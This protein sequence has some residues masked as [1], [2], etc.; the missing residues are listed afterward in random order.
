[1]LQTAGAGVATLALS[2]LSLLAQKEEAKGFT[3][4]K[5]P[6]AYD[7][8]E[9]YIDAET[10]KIHHDKHHAAYV[11]NL[12]AALKGHPKFLSMSIDELM[13]NVGEVPAKIRQAVIDNGGGHLNHS[14]FWEI[15]GPKKGGEPKGALAKAIDKAFGSFEKFKKEL[16]TAAATQFGSGWGWLA[17]ARGKLVVLKAA[18]QD[19]TYLAGY[20]PLLGVDVWEHAYYLKYKNERPKY[21]AA[22]WNVVNW[23]AVA[24]RYGAKG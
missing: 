6:Y 19:P 9:P 18:N 11:R 10:M 22:W 15:M 1:M 17:V 5:L 8:L 12:N 24:D 3:V 14:I 7:A 16:S 21:I 2:P 23:D 20:R 4:P 13:R